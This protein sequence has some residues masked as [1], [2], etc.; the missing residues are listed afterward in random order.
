[1]SK[2]TKDHSLGFLQRVLK[3]L[4]LIIG[5]I[6]MVIPFVWMFTT[7]FKPEVEVLIWPPK[8]LPKAPTYQNFIDLFRQAPFFRYFM[9]SVLISGISTIS[10][11]MISLVGGFIFS[12]YRFPGKNFLFTVLIVTAIVPFESYVIPLYTTMVKWGWINTY[13]G[14]IAPYLVM[15]FG[16]F[17]LR[18]HIGSTISDEL[19]DAARIDGCSEF[20]ILTRIVLPLS[21]SSGGALG[22][23][24]FTQAW[25]AFM[26]PLL[27]ANKKEMFNMEIG[28]TMFQY[29][30]STN[31]SL[32]MAGSV[33][34][35]VP[36][37]IIFV[38]LRRQIIESISL[39]GLKG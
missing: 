34:S 37:I 5:S 3:H 22:I 28:L 7:A 30:F 31:Y 21:K 2:M 35:V 25:I 10:I 17:L 6:I 18:Q 13:R 20:G 24:A 9:N 15:S 27:L 29:R 36:M 39:T 23:F 33:I 1:M 11:L 26:W 32:L 38:V 8:L 14:I 4:A 16:I 19:M 12:K